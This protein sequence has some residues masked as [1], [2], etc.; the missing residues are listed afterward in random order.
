[1]RLQARG[2][3]SDV[4][5]WVLHQMSPETLDMLLLGN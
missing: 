4:T 3:G 1:V 2:T 5:V